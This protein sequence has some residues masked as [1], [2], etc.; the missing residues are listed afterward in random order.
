MSNNI[1]VHYLCIS[2][3]KRNSTRNVFIQT[4]KWYVNIRYTICMSLCIFVDKFV[5][6]KMPIKTT[7][8]TTLPHTNIFVVL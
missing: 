5:Y 3:Y 1:V 8:T 7:H 2:I 6:G 4:N